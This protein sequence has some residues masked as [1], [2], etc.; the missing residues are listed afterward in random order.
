[1][2]LK[3]SLYLI[4]GDFWRV[5]QGCTNSWRLNFGRWHLIFWILIKGRASCHPSRGRN[6]EA[7]PTFFKNLC[8][9]VL[10][11]KNNKLACLK[12]YLST[13]WQNIIRSSWTFFIYWTMILTITNA[14]I[15]HFRNEKLT[16]ND[17]CVRKWDNIPQNSSCNNFTVKKN[18]FH[19]KSC[20]K[21]L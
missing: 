15:E 8:T 18:S 1:M 3:W 20:I 19:L 21:I 10:C 11:S 12:S 2:D 14:K 9:L 7:A 13:D 5:F 4:F 16:W 6:F 17:Q